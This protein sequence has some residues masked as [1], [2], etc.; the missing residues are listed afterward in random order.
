MPDSISV[1]IPCRRGL[2]LADA[3]LSVEIESRAID[4]LALRVLDDF[5]D[6]FQVTQI[7]EALV[8]DL[9]TTLEPSPGP[10]LDALRHHRSRISLPWASFLRNEISPRMHRRSGALRQ[11]LHETNHYLVVYRQDTIASPG[12][13]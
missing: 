5:R 8:E 10:S 4:E 2:Y 1:V 3:L 9:R 6:K 7:V 11:R 12:D 13:V